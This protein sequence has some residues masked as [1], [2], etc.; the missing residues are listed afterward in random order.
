MNFNTITSSKINDIKAYVYSG[1]SIMNK[2]I[3]KINFSKFN[4]FEKEL[5]PLTIKKFKSDFCNLDGFWYSIDNMKDLESI[6]KKN[7]NN[8]FKIIKNLEK[9]IKNHE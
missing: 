6:K 5:Y 3:L 4:N 8:N 2:K 9:K 7:N 1:M